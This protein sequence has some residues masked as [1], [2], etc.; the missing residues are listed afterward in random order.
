MNVFVIGILNI[1]L[2]NIE[3]ALCLLLT[4]HFGFFIA[5]NLDIAKQPAGT[6]INQVEQNQ[7]CYEF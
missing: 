5:L 6:A 2:V 3:F 7:E 4:T 1:P